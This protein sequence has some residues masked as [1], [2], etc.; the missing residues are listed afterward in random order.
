MIIKSFEENGYLHELGEQDGLVQEG[1]DLLLGFNRLV[2][3]E[4][5]LKEGLAQPM[6]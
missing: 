6:T 1:S 5:Q 2:R 4:A 3:P